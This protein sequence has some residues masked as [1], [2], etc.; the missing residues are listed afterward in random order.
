MREASWS[1]VP[2]AKCGLSSVGPCHHKSLRAPPPPRLVGLYSD[3]LC[4]AATPAYANIW[5]A[6]GAVSPNSTIVRTKSRRDIFPAFTSATRL[7]KCPSFMVLTSQLP[8]EIRIARG[9]DVIVKQMLIVLRADV[10]GDLPLRTP[11]APHPRP[12]LMEG[13]RI[14]HREGCFHHL[15]VVDYS[16]ALY[17]VELVGVRRAVN[18][19]ERLDALPDRVDDKGVPLIMDDRLAVP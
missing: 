8:L 19:N 11:V 13:V 14:V 5:L 7:R 12:R 17:D 3:S 10:F 6:S 2:T 18:V 4:A 9:R 15:A 1:F 16:P